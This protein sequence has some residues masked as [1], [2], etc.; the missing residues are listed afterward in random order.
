MIEDFGR[1]G[2]AAGD[3]PD[4]AGPDEAA[5][6]GRAGE[7]VRRCQHD[8]FVHRAL[9]DLAFR[10]PEACLWAFRSRDARAYLQALWDHVTAECGAGDPALSAEQIRLY[11]LTLAGFPCIVVEMPEPEARAEAHFVAL[12]FRTASVGRI[13]VADEP[14]VLYWTL[15]RRDRKGD[16]RLCEWRADGTHRDHGKGPDP[17]LEAFLAA[18]VAE[19]VRLAGPRSRS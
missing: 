2:D 11:E 10:D 13:E 17:T 5:L 7:D 4:E 14:A 8:S 6:S 18:V 16:T 15:E 1:A 19:M 12:V 3:E 9:R